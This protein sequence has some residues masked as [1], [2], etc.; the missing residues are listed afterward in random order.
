MENNLTCTH[1]VA[2][3]LKCISNH[4]QH[5]L[6]ARVPPPPPSLSCTSHFHYAPSIWWCDVW[7]KR[8]TEKR[9]ELCVNSERCKSSA[10]SFSRGMVI[11]G[12][13][14][15]HKG[16]MWRAYWVFRL[17]YEYSMKLP[18]LDTCRLFAL[19]R[20]PLRRWFER[21]LT[22]ME[23]TQRLDKHRVKRT[24]WEPSSSCNRFSAIPFDEPEAAAF[25]FATRRRK[26]KD[27]SGA[28]TPSTKEITMAREIRRKSG[29]K[30]FMLPTR[31]Q[32][33][34][35]LTAPKRPKVLFPRNIF[36]LVA[37]HH[38]LAVDAL[39]VRMLAT[40][41]RKVCR[42]FEERIMAW[43]WKGGEKSERKTC[44]WKKFSRSLRQP[45]LS[46]F[47]AIKSSFRVSFPFIFLSG[48]NVEIGWD[49][50]CCYPYRMSVGVA[51]RRK[52]TTL[53]WLHEI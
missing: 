26:T 9:Q 13:S 15:P 43:W 17:R 25:Y 12:F 47:Y 52:H 11:F 45:R 30:S 20:S 41:P 3:R 7:K 1:L 39:A 22:G 5:F 27:W 36:Q 21:K 16:S 40:K 4:F 6:R 33:L 10:V 50:W 23:L 2:F 46:R 42:W 28:N 35:R 37:P 24:W 49:H 31:L 29:Y 18:S 38:T 53:I 14:L 8:R 48:V 51:W 44:S 19:S 34:T 32:F